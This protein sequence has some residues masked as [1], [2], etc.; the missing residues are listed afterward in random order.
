MDRTQT[1]RSNL[2]R[3]LAGVAFVVFAVGALAAAS[4][5]IARYEWPKSHPHAASAE[6]ALATSPAAPT[7]VGW[8]GEGSGGVGAV[9][10]GDRSPVPTS[11]DRSTRG[12]GGEPGDGRDDARDRSSL[13]AESLRFAHRIALRRTAG[14][15]KRPQAWLAGEIQ[16]G[17]LAHLRRN[18]SADADGARA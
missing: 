3:R 16:A 2:R 17:P 18:G 4:S 1:T 9:R 13:R 10:P 15:T 12:A 6:G 14:E 5:S 8:D 7:R 11:G